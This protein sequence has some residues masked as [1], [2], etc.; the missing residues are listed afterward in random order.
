[1]PRSRRKRNDIQFCLD[2]NF[3]IEAV[4]GV[5]NAV[6]VSELPQFSS[7]HR[8]QSRAPDVDIAHWCHANSHV[9]VTQD[10]DFTSRKQ[11]AQAIHLTGVEVIFFSY[12]LIGVDQHIQ[13][14]STRVPLWEAQLSKYDYEARVWMQHPIGELRWQKSRHY[15]R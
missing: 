3:S 14:I 2:A 12:E 13:A 15:L 7:A 6:H 10:T 8:G 5:A 1:M 9:L 11:R 4:Q